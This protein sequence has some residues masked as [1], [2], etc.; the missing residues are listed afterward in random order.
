MRKVCSEKTGSG[1]SKMLVQVG[2]LKVSTTIDLMTIRR[3]L[4]SVESTTTIK[5]ATMT[6]F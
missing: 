5:S 4:L 3:E 1:W 6:T 2:V